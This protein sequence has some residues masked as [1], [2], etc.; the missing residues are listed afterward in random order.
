MSTMTI[1]WIIFIGIALA[2]WIVSYALKHKF[3]KYSM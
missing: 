1:Y 3:E 2:S